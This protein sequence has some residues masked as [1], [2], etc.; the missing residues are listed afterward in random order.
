M[1]RAMTAIREVLDQFDRAVDRFVMLVNIE[2]T[3]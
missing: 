3:D 1:A 2:K